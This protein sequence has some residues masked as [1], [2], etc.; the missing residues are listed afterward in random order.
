MNL[1]RMAPYP[2]YFLLYITM[3]PHSVMSAENEDCLSLRYNPH[4][5]NLS[6]L[7]LTAAVEVMYYF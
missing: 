5:I 3:Q 4:I 1:F 6:L 7:R 2:L